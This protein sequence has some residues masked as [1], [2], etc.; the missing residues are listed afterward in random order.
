MKHHTKYSNFIKSAD[1]KIW[2]ISNFPLATTEFQRTA[3]YQ[4]NLGRINN[5][6][7]SIASLSDSKIVQQVAGHR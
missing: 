2:H 6:A 3:F 1:Q 5:I 7:T 4:V